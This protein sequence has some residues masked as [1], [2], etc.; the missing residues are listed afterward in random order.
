M[1]SLLPPNASA[2]ERAL[3]EAT[4]RV[5]AVPVA[6]ADLWNPQTCPA[7]ALPWLAW[8][9]SVDVWDSAWSES[10]KRSVIA[11]SI[12]IHRHKGTVWAVREALRA[13]GYA[14]ATL[15]EGLPRLNYDGTQLYDA[16]ETYYGGS[17][18]ALFDVRAD[19]G[20]DVGV[21]VESRAQLS[22][23]IDMAKPVSRHLRAI[24]FTSTTSDTA[25][26]SEAATMVAHDTQADVLPWG[27]RYDGT[28]LH[29]S[30]SVPVYDGAELFDGASDFTGFVV[31]DLLFDNAWESETLAGR[32]SATDQQASTVCYDGLTDYNG[33]LNMG[34]I[35]APLYDAMMTVATKRHY[36]HNGRRTYGSGKD[37]DGTQVFNGAIDFAPQLTY[38]GIHTIQEVRV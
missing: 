32:V 30:G 22:V 38:A 15:S 10:V 18:W 2:S 33:L 7:T 26:I 1:S 21:D 34:S 28:V 12:E 9:L 31:G 6:I 24:T 11:K 27:I 36:L 17:R 8:A 4:S 5:G 20:E 35:R 25:T 14:D 29:D 19:L 13:G 23:L 37:Y 3:D 16:V